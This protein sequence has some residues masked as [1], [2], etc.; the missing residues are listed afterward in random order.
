MGSRVEEALRDV[1]RPRRGGGVCLRSAS[2]AAWC[3]PY[4][5]FYPTRMPL[6]SAALKILKLKAA[7]QVI[8][9]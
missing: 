7:N 8:R 6:K 4:R 9:M 1:D 2:S 5:N 3:C